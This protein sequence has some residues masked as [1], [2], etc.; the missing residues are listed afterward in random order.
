MR[1]YTLLFGVALYCIKVTF[2][3]GRS[4]YILAIIYIIVYIS[5]VNSEHACTCIY[6]YLIAWDIG[7]Y[8]KLL[9]E[10]NNSQYC[11]INHVIS[12][13]LPSPSSTWLKLR[14]FTEQ[15]AWMR[16]AQCALKFNWLKLTGQYNW[17]NG[18][19]LPSAE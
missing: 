3:M 13:L 14:H 1:N 2:G 12:C 17:A 5:L 7:Q 15:Y 11:P 19:I 9:H 4:I 16:N 18:K 6:V 10:C 8:G